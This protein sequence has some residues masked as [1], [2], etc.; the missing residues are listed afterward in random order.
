MGRTDRDRTS[1]PAA[2]APT[3]RTRSPRRL[4]GGAAVWLLARAWRVAFLCLAVIAAASPAAAADSDAVARVVRQHGPVTVLRAAVPRPL[5]IGA[6]L[7]RGDRIVTGGDAKVEVEFG[8]GSTL[9]IGP[10]TDVEVTEYAPDGRGRL[11][12][13]IG[14]I[15]T[16]L[17][18]LWSGGF[19]VWTQAAIA[20]VRSTE[21]VTEAYEDR[22][23][24]FVVSGVVTVAG[25][26]DGTKVSLAEGEGTDVSVGGAPTPPKRWGSA[27]VED[28]L[29]RTR[30]P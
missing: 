20:S 17:S 26:A 5:Y 7:Y 8:D 2:A 10:D 3:G 27:R 15:R 14:I 21:W 12:L 22:A 4:P 6:A 18:E 16:N 24:V 1:E 11:T 28:V 30:L 25:T 9:A 29:A 19:E 23:A 13:L